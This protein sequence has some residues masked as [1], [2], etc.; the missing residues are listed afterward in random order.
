M[1]LEFKINLEPPRSLVRLSLV[2]GAVIAAFGT[3]MAVVHA[4][5][6][7]PNL[8]AKQQPLSADQMNTNFAALAAAIPQITSAEQMTAVTTGA[9]SSWTDITWVGGNINVPYAVGPSNKLLVQV[10]GVVE[11]GGTAST[12]SQGR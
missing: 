3:A 9:N 1:K 12:S 7:V 2:L 8:F 11:S 5:V 10:T 6:K 4:D